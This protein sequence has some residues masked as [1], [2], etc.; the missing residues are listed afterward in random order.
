MKNEPA[1]TYHRFLDEAG[2]T[3]FYGKGK[4]NIVGNEGVS[5]AFILG[6]VKFK[7]PLEPIRQHI[8]LLVSQ[9]EADAYFT[10]VPSIQ[11]KVAKSGFF[12]H[13]T[14]D[15]PEVRKLLYDYI[16]TL[17]CSFEAV[18]ARKIQGIFEQ[19]HN[20]RQSEFY[21]D[22]LSH[23][24]K[25][26]L[27]KGGKLVL[28]IAQRADST[29]HTNL[30][31]ALS[32][33]TARHQAGKQIKPVKTQIV[34]NVQPYENEPLLCITDYF[35]WA[36]QRIFERGETRYYNF[37]KDKISLV[38]DLYDHTRWKNSGNYYTS[39]QLLSSANR[40]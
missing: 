26:K 4:I 31:L 14:D 38:I 30:G 5:K 9:V 23:L 8:R 7:T 33:A 3:T 2:D 36:V 35:C 6:S 18:V 16:Q 25:N 10:E 34:F 32:K 21:A 19:K 29:K 20:G 28:N 17:D 12:F 1:Y 13:G 27:N 37:L 24:L 39:K 11:K 22:L 40:L 15:L